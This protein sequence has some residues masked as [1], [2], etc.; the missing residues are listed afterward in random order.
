[1][2]D[3]M[4]VSSALGSKF[5]NGYPVGRVT[6]VEQ[7]K[8]EPFMYIVLEPMQQIYDAEFVVILDDL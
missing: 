5:P 7:R 8:N 2:V 1:M 4:F 3:D 6:H